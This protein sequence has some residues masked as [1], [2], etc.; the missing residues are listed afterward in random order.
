MGTRH[1]KREYYLPNKLTQS[2]RLYLQLIHTPY[3]HFLLR[4][5]FLSTILKLQVVA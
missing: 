5:K 1:C 3:Y 4:F 2:M